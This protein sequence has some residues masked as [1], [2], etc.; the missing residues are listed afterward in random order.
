[1][2]VN[3]ES[4]NKIINSTTDSVDLT[5]G[6]Y[7]LQYEN[8]ASPFPS[9]DGNAYLDVNIIKTGFYHISVS[10]IPVER[11]NTNVKLRNNPVSRI[12]NDF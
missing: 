1:M 12:I 10:Y 7:L 8:A 2:L 6:N 3:A 11:E 4:T 9:E 5:Y